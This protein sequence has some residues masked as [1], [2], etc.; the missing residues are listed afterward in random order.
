MMKRSMLSA[1]VF[2]AMAFSGI[3]A[4]H[5]ADG[6]I[7]F[8]G[9]ILD[10]ACTVAVTPSVAM[11]SI[12]KSAFTNAGS[13]AGYTKFNIVLNKCPAAQKNA[14][15]VFDGMADTDN[16]SLLKLTTGAG[17]A[18]GLGV[19]IYEDVNNTLLPMHMPSSEYALTETVDNNLAF[20]A[21]YM[22]TTAAVTSGTANATTDFTVIY[23]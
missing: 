8:T 18:T 22:A 1:M 4:V 3:N 5:A 15:L 11:G 6:T 10:S 20:T 19:A 21:K 14:R 17:V 7:N 9:T 2:S 13:E 23:N 12:T 16:A